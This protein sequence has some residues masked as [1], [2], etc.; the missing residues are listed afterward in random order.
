MGKTV[1]GSLLIASVAEKDSGILLRIQT[2]ENKIEFCLLPVGEVIGDINLI[3]PNGMNAGVE[4]QKVCDL[5][6][7]MKKDKDGNMIVNPNHIP[8]KITLVEKG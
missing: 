6:N 2:E 3:I 5:L 7:G 4:L 1:K 8:K